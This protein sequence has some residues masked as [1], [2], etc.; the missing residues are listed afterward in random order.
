MNRTYTEQA[1]KLDTTVKAEINAVR[2][3]SQS[4]E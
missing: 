2:I 1:V 3:L 4:D